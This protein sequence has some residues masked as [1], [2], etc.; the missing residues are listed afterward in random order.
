[1]K[2]LIYLHTNPLICFLIAH[3][4]PELEKYL[5]ILR[6]AVTSHKNQTKHLKI[7][8]QNSRKKIIK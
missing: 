3:F 4:E 2:I 8:N 5:V 1:M 7:N 6:T